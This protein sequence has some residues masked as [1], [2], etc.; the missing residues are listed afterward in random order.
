[1]LNMPLEIVVGSNYVKYDT[2]SKLILQA[3]GGSQADH[4]NIYIDIYSIIKPMFSSNTEIKYD[5][6]SDLELSADLINMC[7]HYRAFFYRLGVNTKIFLI[8]GINTPV[9]NNILCP[10]YNENFIRSYTAKTKIRNIIES[11]MNALSVLCKSLPEIYFFNIGD[12]EVS[13]YI[14]YL[15]SQ[16]KLN[17]KTIYPTTENMVISKDV[18]SLQLVSSGCTIL[19]PKKSKGM[20]NSFIISHSNFWN[21]FMV[22]IRGLKPVTENIDPVFFSSML[23]MTRVPER[24]MSSVKSIPSTYSI[25][26]KGIEMGYIQ[27]ET[28]F[29]QSTIN[30]VLEIMGVNCNYTTLE[31]RWKSIS[32]KFMAQYIIPNSPK[33]ANAELVDIQDPNGVKEIVSRYYEKSPIDLDRL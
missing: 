12:M 31:M 21:S 28:G 27:T 15:I 10:G 20:D 7:A 14:E 3:Y 25:L 2:L 23:A 33:I 5:M 8:Y 16:H 22:E 1:M 18:L 26:C 24:C 17:D 4:L 19:R 29:S 30:K 6:T 32:T 13:A 9:N 11:N